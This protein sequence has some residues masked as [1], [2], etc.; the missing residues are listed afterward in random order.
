M[1]SVV[2]SYRRRASESFPTQP[3]APSGLTAETISTPAIALNW[4]DNSTDETGFEIQR[5]PDGSTWATIATVAVDATHYEDE[6]GPGTY[7]YRVRAT[8]LLPSV[9]S[10][11]A[12][13]VSWS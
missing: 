8:A 4:T 3:N 7:Y 6:S 9:W 11:I 10:D 1:S 5:S 13:P 12:G 2:P